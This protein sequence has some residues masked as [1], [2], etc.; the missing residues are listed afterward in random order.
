[1]KL[2]DRWVRDLTS[3]AGLPVL[4]L[5]FAGLLAWNKI[6]I[7][8]EFVISLFVAELTIY[9][10]RY[11]YFRQR[12]FG[13][14][15]GFKSLYERL[16]ESSFPSA[17]SARAAVIALVLSQP[18]TWNLRIFLWI[19]ATSVCLSR[20]YLKRHHPSDV[21]VGGVLGLIISYIVVLLV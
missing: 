8:I 4:V 1:M 2:M 11:F 3:I 18:L 5:F 12:P 21:V 13:K 10:I 6:G 14:K 19:I 9:V 7:A 16:D 20:V 17:H 15:D